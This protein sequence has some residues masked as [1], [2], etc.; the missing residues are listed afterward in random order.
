MLQFGLISEY[1]RIENGKEMVAE[2]DRQDGWTSKQA[3]FMQSL[4]I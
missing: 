4:L 1:V 2:I 3:I